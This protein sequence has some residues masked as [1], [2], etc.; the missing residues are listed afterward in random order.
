M[1]D[2]HYPVESPVIGSP[3]GM[4]WHKIHKR[5]QLH[6]GIDFANTGPILAAYNGVVR[7]IGY[8]GH[9][10]RGYGHYIYIS[11]GGG[12][13]T[14]YA[15]MA[16][17]SP[18]KV[19]DRVMALQQV[20]TVGS[21]GASTGPHCHFET[22]LNWKRVDPMPYLTKTK[23]KVRVTGRYDK[24]TKKAWQVFLTE[25]GFYSGQIDGDIGPKS[26][27]GIQKSISSLR[28]DYVY[29]VPQPVLKPGVLDENTRKGV[30]R[31]LGVEPDGDWGRIT[32]T[33][34]QNALNAGAYSGAK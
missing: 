20:G 28:A 4:R 17:R 1:I 2:L 23:Q 21:T 11:H 27:L 16:Y 15:H 14:L 13:Q 24:Q 19:G 6:K 12:L 22:I 29:N 5:Y 9:K 31:A 3:F 33:K 18:L 32:M 34:L 30:Q 25:R 10:T 7:K 8:W 26:I